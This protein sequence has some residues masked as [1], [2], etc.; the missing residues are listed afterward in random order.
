[1]IPNIDGRGRAVRARGGWILL[2]VAVLVAVLWPR[3][4]SVGG[5]V[6]VLSPAA[7]GLFMLFEARKGWCAVRACGIK[8]PL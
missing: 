4:W 2:S 7:G 6:A 5:W 8:T 1:M 3:P